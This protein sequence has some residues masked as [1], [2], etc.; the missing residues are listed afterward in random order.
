MRY[1]L[2]TKKQSLNYS[3]TLKVIRPQKQVKS[4]NSWAVTFKTKPNG[5]LNL[6]MRINK[7]NHNNKGLYNC[8]KM[9]LLASAFKYLKTPKATKHA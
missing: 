6:T 5:C 1:W 3:S 4:L 2:T 9:N 8:K 7:I